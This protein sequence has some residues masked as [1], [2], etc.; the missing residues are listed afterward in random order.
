MS[1]EF[2]FIWGFLI[3]DGVGALIALIVAHKV[4]KGVIKKVL[5]E[6]N[7]R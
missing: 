3:G 2:Q 4:V 1:I 6:Y 7:V 5:N